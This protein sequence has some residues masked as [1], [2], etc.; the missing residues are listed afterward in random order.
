MIFSKTKQPNSLPPEI[1]TA[2]VYNLWDIL[3]GYYESLEYLKMLRVY[4]HD[5][6]LKIKLDD[7]ISDISGRSKKVENI[8]SHFRIRTP[9]SPRKEVPTLVNSQPIPDELIGKYLLLI[10]QERIE[11]KVRCLRNAQHVDKVREFFIYLVNEDI[12]NLNSII[13]Y[14]KL[15][16]WIE[17]PILVQNIPQD[18]NE[19]IDVA[20]AYHIWDHLVFR[21]LNIEQTNLFVQLAHDG[22][23]KLLLGKGLDILKKQIKELEKEANC[24]GINFPQQP[25]KELGHMENT[26]FIDDDFIF[27]L[28]LN[29]LNS[30]S[31]IHAQA[32][33]KATTN[34]RIRNLFAR[35]LTEEIDAIDGLIKYGKVKGWLV[36]PPLYRL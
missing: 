21:Y 30:A 33:K 20:E 8:M 9:D 18:C 26:E 16:G 6:D 4:A 17:Q 12:K 28:L 29:G 32:V 31:I 24:F 35:L 15:K 13:K 34:D 36:N 10:A 1:S 7:T 11:M 5:P 27:N 2:E 3:S 14:L 22:D 25:P 19:K 23:F